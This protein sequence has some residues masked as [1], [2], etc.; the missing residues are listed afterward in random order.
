MSE[1]TCPYVATGNDGTKFCRLAEHTGCV[2]NEWKA[3]AEKAETERDALMSLMQ[4]RQAELSEDQVTEAQGLAN[5]AFME[6]IE[7]AEKAEEKFRLTIDYAGE[8]TERAHKAETVVQAAKTLIR[9]LQHAPEARGVLLSDNPSLEI[10]IEKVEAWEAE[11]ET[12]P[13]PAP[14]RPSCA[15]FQQQGGC[16]PYGD[17]YLLCVKRCCVRKVE[18][19]G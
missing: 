12:A 13:K 11:K 10:L 16:C 4:A 8:L 5:A 7:R 6:A 18:N 15:H 19:A 1:E 3:R 14:G 9:Y 2:L 17:D